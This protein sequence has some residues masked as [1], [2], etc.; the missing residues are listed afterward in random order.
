MK[1]PALLKSQHHRRRK[2]RARKQIIVTNSN[3]RGQRE[4]KNTGGQGR[5]K[6]D[7]G[8]VAEMSSKPNPGSS[9]GPHHAELRDGYSKE[10]EEHMQKTWKWGRP[11][12]KGW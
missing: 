10:R 3:C 5:A 2:T 8:A 1:G 9:G 6:A 12:I 4:R 7:F 11:G